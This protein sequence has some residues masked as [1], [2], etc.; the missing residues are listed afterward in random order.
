MKDKDN[1][2]E[3]GKGKF[4]G[5]AIKKSGIKEEDVLKAQ[6]IKDKR[7]RGGG[8]DEEPPPSPRKPKGPAVIIEA[9]LEPEPEPE[10]AVQPVIEEKDVVDSKKVKGRGP[11]FKVNP[12]MDAFVKTIGGNVAT[13]NL[14]SDVAHWYPFDCAPLDIVFGGGIPSGKTIEFFGWES[15]GK[16]T[17]A[18]EALKAFQRYWSQ[19][20]EDCLCLWIESESAF[21]KVRADYMDLDLTNVG[22][23][24]ADSVEAG[25]AAIDSFLDYVST[26]KIPGF[27]C[28]DTIAA[29]LTEN[30][31]ADSWA[32]GIG[33]KAR[34]I[35]KLMKKVSLL[36]GATN[37]TL[38]FCNQM[39]STFPTYG[40]KQKPEDES[41]GGGGIKFHSSIRCHMRR[42]GPPIEQILPNGQKITKG[43][44]VEL[45]TK[46]NKLALPHQK[47]FLTINGES[48][49]DTLETLVKFLTFNK[50]IE[51]KGSWKYIEFNDDLI[52]FQNTE[53]LR[54]IINVKNPILKV[55]MDYLCYKHYSSIS[56]LAKVRSL[57]RLWEFER[58]L[59][60]ETTT[61]TDREY[62]MASLI[63]R[64]F[65]EEQDREEG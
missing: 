37:S 10:S 63:N 27:V 50:F 15:S 30:E 6:E 22:I 64:K 42:M 54:E 1:S 2:K 51:I 29:V 20:G 26:H 13:D 43:I 9:V 48:G 23:K 45:K 47:C 19:R 25:F 4:S 32:G 41:P 52:R 55:Y 60:I 28:W 59:G 40:M 46:K 24:E 62:T 53:G 33:E 3:K 12:L 16:S 21:D 31:K 57:E 36:L 35:R 8:I 5:L 14:S 11:S 49:L 61:I 7:K 39:Y 17:L 34:M 44:E 58:K 56:A 18:Q 38:L 65:L